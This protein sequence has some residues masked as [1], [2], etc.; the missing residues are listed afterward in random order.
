MCGP[1]LRPLLGGGIKGAAD[2]PPL[3]SLHT[4]PDKLVINGLLHKDAGACCAAL[5]CVEKHPLMGLFYSQVTLPSCFLD[6]LA[7]LAKETDLEFT[8]RNADQQPDRSHVHERNVS[9]LRTTRVVRRPERGEKPTLVYLISGLGTGE[10]I[11]WRDAMRAAGSLFTSPGISP[12]RPERTE[13]EAATAPTIT[14]TL[15][16]VVSC[17]FRSEEDIKDRGNNSNNTF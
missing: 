3:G 13:W 14:H 7:D 17:L 2:Y 16:L 6:Q 5:A 4:P 1:H 9:A 15:P 12:A 11:S 10:G 8:H